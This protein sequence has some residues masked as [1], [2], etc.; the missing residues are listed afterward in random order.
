MR[1]S[2]CDRVISLRILLGIPS[3]GS[4][5]RSP[6]VC[7]RLCFDF[8]SS[9]LRMTMPLTFGICYDVSPIKTHQHGYSSITLYFHSFC[10]PENSIAA[11]I[12]TFFAYRL[13]SVDS[14]SFSIFLHCSEAGSLFRRLAPS[15]E[16]SSIISSQEPC[17]YSALVISVVERDR[18]Q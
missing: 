7:I 15:G 17:F 6:D 12:H 3:A 14:N 9:H 8:T 2:G 10:D 1:P 18:S 16:W 13:S 4:F 11:D 5:G